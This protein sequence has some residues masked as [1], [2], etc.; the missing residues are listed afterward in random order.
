MGELDEGDALIAADKRRGARGFFDGWLG[1]R[2]DSDRRPDDG[3]RL[4][5]FLQRHIDCVFELDANGNFVGGNARAEALLGFSH[6]ELRGNPVSIVVPADQ[7]PIMRSQSQR[8]LAGETVEYHSIVA[9]KDG[10]RL[11]V[12]VT[13]IPGFERGKVA[14][15]YAIA[16]DITAERSA[17]TELIEYTDR[18]RALNAV[19]VSS[20]ASARQQIA[21]ILEC[22]TQLLGLDCA[23]V[24][25]IDGTTLEVNYAYGESGIAV[26]TTYALSAT[27]APQ[28]Q[29]TQEPLL[30]ADLDAP[31]W[32]AHPARNVFP[33]RSYAGSTYAVEGASYGTVGFGG[34][35]PKAA[36]FGKYDTDLIESIC[37][38]AG[39]AVERALAEA[40]L[41]SLAFRDP[42]TGLAN[43]TLMNEQLEARLAAARRAGTAVAV[44]F[45]DLDK[46]K[47]VND[48]Y[49]HAAGDEVLRVVARRLERLTRESDTLARLGGDE[50]VLIQSGITGPAEAA[51][52]AQ[53][54]VDAL[55]V[56]IEGD[57]V[58]YDIG[59]SIGIAL[60]PADAREAVELLKRADEALYE[61]KK[62]S[63]GSARFA[64]SA[65]DGALAAEGGPAALVERRASVSPNEPAAAGNATEVPYPRDRRRR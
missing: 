23:L 19:A 39:F 50:F 43:R 48:A 49:G 15:M 34:L 61:V 12:R 58:T 25:K 9:T 65:F 53:R 3:D 38:L 10:R 55:A 54:I 56:P 5:A 18:I 57:G 22:G 44:H 20:G 41:N 2:N 30:V 60:F 16:R 4:S 45:L 24:T 37:T 27:Y 46:F 11:P 26:G 29:A 42:L 13:A 28:M 51:R 8:V 36:G 47:A 63:R 59:A 31:P 21:D 52:V 7:L 62:S 32:N 14:R 40:R 6:E 35:G 17:V 33:W 64:N 1:S